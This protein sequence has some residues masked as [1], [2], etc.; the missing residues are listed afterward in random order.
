M[1][2]EIKHVGKLAKNRRKVVVAYRVIPGENPPMNALVIDTAT[3]TD[4]D[5]DVLMRT[6]ENN[7]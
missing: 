3:L 6:V 5:H 1:A 7:A 4:S 2:T